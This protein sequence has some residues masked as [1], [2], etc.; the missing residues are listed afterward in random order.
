MPPLLASQTLGFMCECLRGALAPVV[1]VL[2][3]DG[4]SGDLRLPGTSLGGRERPMGFGG[5]PV[6]AALGTGPLGPGLRRGDAVGEL[7]A[8]PASRGTSVVWQYEH[9]S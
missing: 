8:L 2:I 3:E 1:A 7:T 5:M 4:S 6:G 9:T